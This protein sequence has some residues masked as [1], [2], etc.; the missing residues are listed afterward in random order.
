MQHAA[1]TQIEYYPP[2]HGVY[3]KVQRLIRSGPSSL[4][5]YGL[6]RG[7]QSAGQV[8]P[9]QLQLVQPHTVQRHIACI[10]GLRLGI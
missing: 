1:F 2:G 6:G 5:L 10:M 8:P 3:L 7:S 9:R 4:D